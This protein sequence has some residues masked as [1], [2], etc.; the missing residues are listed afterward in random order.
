MEETM[1]LN[2]LWFILVAVLYAGFFLLEG[3]D[4]GVGM[5]LPFL[6]RNDSE[7]RA[8]LGAIGPHWDANE[9]WL[10]TAGGATFAA[11]PGWYAAMFSGLY[12]LLLILL[13]A[14]IAR[15][16]AIEFRGRMPGAR[17]RGA[18]DAAIALGSL[19]ASVVLGAVFGNLL[20]GIPL[21]E[22]GIP[23]G[24]GLAPFNLY[25][26]VCGAAVAGLFLLH[27]ANF[28]GLKLN[29]EPGGRVRAAAKGLWVAALALSA[30]F[31]A[32]TF[33]RTDLPARLGYGALFLPA[34]MLLGLALIGV[35]LW[36]RRAGWAFVFGSLT[37]VFF[38]A[39]FFLAL[40]PRVMV[41]SL[42]P[43]YSLTVAGAASSEYSLR[44][45]TIVSLI[46]LPIVIAYQAWSYWV[47][48]RR[49]A[50]G[51]EEEGY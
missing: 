12:P 14:L 4:F 47:F 40:Y 33:L 45:M 25:A 11:F 27:G 31:L 21:G 50:A 5:L 24:G 13:L 32:A 17:W 39:A 51:E 43:E 23:T 20:G 10:I 36:K 18:W 9:V 28:L 46:F 16:A 41:S 7:R 42:G 1:Q 2:V 29:G 44:V 48:R 35:C 3:F 8:V 15:G 30:A 22:N 19:T 38:A 6:G 26:L 37:V 49:V 34:G